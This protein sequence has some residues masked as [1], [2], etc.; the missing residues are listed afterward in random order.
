[1]PG[2]GCLCEAQGAVFDSDAKLSGPDLR[3]WKLQYEFW[4]G[5]KVIS[6]CSMGYL[7]STSNSN[8]FSL[9]MLT[10][11]R[12][13][14][15]FKTS[16]SH[17]YIAFQRG[18]VQLM[19]SLAQKKKSKQKKSI[20]CTSIPHA[21]RQKKGVSE[22]P[23][24]KKP[25]G[26]WGRVSQCTNHNHSHISYTFQQSTHKANTP[27]KCFSEIFCS[28]GIKTTFTLLFLT[29]KL[30]LKPRCS[31]L[32]CFQR[33]LEELKPPPSADQGKRTVSIPLLSQSP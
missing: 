6:F 16:L 21:W 26:L 2:C 13:L 23:H 9:A 12:Q 32:L 22:M 14:W 31:W 33:K 20:F 17:S 29:E 11:L 25:F 24:T 30:S 10:I 8:R 18:C 7:V 28:P 27:Q 5:K 15:I 19:T 4:G 3:L 1:M